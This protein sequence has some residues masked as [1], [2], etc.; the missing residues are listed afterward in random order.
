[1]GYRERRAELWAERAASY[2]EAGEQIQ[3][4][5]IAQ[6]GWFI[7]TVP[8]ATFVATDRAILVLSGHDVQRLPRDFRFG[9]PSGLYHRIE[10]DRTYKVHRQYH[11]E[12]R[13]ADEALRE[14][15]DRGDLPESR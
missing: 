1:M 5:F 15:Q 3:T 7:F 13:A 2:L 14:M 11:A 12:I 10:L 8:I 6:T 9:E 4:G